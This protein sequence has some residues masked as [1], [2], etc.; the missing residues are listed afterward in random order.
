MVSVKVN[1]GKAKAKIQAMVWVMLLKT[2]NI[3]FES[4]SISIFGRGGWRV[5]INTV[6]EPLCV[7]RKQ[8]IF[9]NCTEK[10]KLGLGRKF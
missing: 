1:A 5:V 3:L 8:S 7:N 9:Y 6:I 10:T 4:I 2:G